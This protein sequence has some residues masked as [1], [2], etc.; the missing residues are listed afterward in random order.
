MGASSRKPALP[1]LTRAD[2]ARHDYDD[3]SPPNRCGRPARPPSAKPEWGWLWQLDPPAEAPPDDLV[4]REQLSDGRSGPLPACRTGR[5]TTPLRD[6]QRDGFD[7]PRLT[8]RRRIRWPT[9]GTAVGTFLVNHGNAMPVQPASLSAVSTGRSRA[10]RSRQ[11]VS[12]M[13]RTAS[14]DEVFVRPLPDSRE[15]P[16]HWLCWATITRNNSTKINR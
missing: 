7:A 10:T 2:L 11:R 16:L 12:L 4:V 8:A 1:Q 14:L 9:T 5:S 15:R 3:P 13:G 6:R